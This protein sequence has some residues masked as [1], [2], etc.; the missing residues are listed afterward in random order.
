MP[1][2]ASAS[3]I[4]WSGAVSRNSPTSPE[5]C[6]S[7]WQ[8]MDAGAVE[9]LRPLVHRV[10]EVG[11]QHALLGVDGAA[12]AAVAALHAALDV[13]ARGA[14]VEAE[15]LG[16]VVEEAVVAIGLFERDLGDAEPL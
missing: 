16:A 14:R 10:G 5:R 4:G 1:P 3:I 12:H 7:E 8:A 9:R 6:A 15:R 2:A 11:D 13:S